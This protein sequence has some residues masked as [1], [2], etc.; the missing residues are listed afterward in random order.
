[1]DLK[2][3]VTRKRVALLVALAA[4][5]TAGGV[6]YATVPGNDTVFAACM[7]KATGTIRLI[8]QTLPSS[9]LRSHCTSLE[10]QIS[11]NQQGPQ[12]IQGPE[13]IQGPKGD[14]GTPGAPGKDGSNGVDGKDGARGPVGP[15][16]P[17]GPQGQQGP[18]GSGFS[19][20]Y[21]L[22]GTDCTDPQTHWPATL[23]VTVGDGAG[24]GGT[25][26]AVSLKCVPATPKTLSIS[27]TG[28]GSF[29]LRIPGATSPFRQCFQ[30][31]NQSAP[32]SCTASVPPDTA[33]DVEADAGTLDG[34]IASWGGVC[35]GHDVGQSYFSVCRVTMDTDKSVSVVFNP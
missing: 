16:G 28:Y 27:W 13:G 32:Y 11:W 8:D 33:V 5:L 20:L 10:T 23:H 3:R 1:M 30:P 34:R 18:A 35:A 31:I 26:G 15:Q 22:E 7:L 25:G 9:N 21:D 4:L 19:N 17:Q 14:N 12:G 24:E 2:L 29:N 6:A